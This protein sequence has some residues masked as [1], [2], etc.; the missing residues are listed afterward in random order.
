MAVLQPSPNARVHIAA[1]ECPWCEQPI[2]NEK[3]EEV[4]RRIAVKEQQ[5]QLE[6][7]ARMRAEIE[8]VRKQ[9]V[10][11]VE[12][13]RAESAVREAAAIERGK[14]EAQAELKAK[15]A[16]AAAASQVAAEREAALA[17]QLAE[18][19]SERDHAAKEAQSKIEAM[20]VASAEREAAAHEQGQKAAQIEFQGQLDLV[21]L[22]IASAREREAGLKAQLTEAGEAHAET[23]RRLTSEMTNR[24]EVARA[25]GMATAHE[26]QR[27]KVMAAESARQAAEARLADVE[28]GYEA[29]LNVRLQ[30]QREALEKHGEAAVN[31][32]KAKAFEEKQKFETALQDLQRQLQKKTAE[33]LGEGAEVDLFDELKAEFPGDTITRVTKGTPGADIIHEIFNNGR[34]CGR[35]VYDSKNRT[36][37]RTEYVTKLKADQ[38]AAEA[39]HAVLASRAFPA[40]RKQLHLVDG[41]IVVNPA[42]A[43]VIANL[44]RRHIVQTHGL[45]VSNEERTRKTEELYAFITSAR[46]N[47]FLH[48]I[49]ARSEDIEELDV[50]EKK[51]H[52]ATWKRRGELVRSVQRSRNQLVEEFER[53]IGAA[54]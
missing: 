10:A 23:I 31:A 40:G 50:K 30:E 21:S 25:T 6:A 54:Q 26:A 43:L 35:I 36:A 47:Q 3:L 41:V 11:A 7:D 45:R 52:E 4:H 24:E 33:E 32:E 39:D 28:A 9:G 42:R 14:K 51:A 15:L 16:E 2:P 44:L 48:D 29:T 38:V 1:E 49:H 5:R 37:W 12:T 20:Q 17:G 18:A 53:I 22:Q 46:C 34:L 8:S 13:A 19:C 27:E